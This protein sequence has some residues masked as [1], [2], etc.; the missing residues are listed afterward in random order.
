MNQSKQELPVLTEREQ[1]IC[2]HLDTLT[3]EQVLA[4]IRIQV[5]RLGHIPAKYEAECVLYL[6]RRFGPWPRLLEKAGVKPVSKNR[7]R[8]LVRRRKKRKSSRKNV[9]ETE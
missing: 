6:K 9:Q 3:D 4:L 2:R 8:K 5:Q 7:Q 1:K